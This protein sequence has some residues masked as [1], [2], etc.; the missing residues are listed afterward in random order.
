MTK[1]FKKTAGTD[2]KDLSFFA[3]FSLIFGSMMGS[4]V[5]DIPQNVAHQAGAIAVII[6]WVITAIGMLS[7]GAAFVYITR[8]R[9]DIQSGIY[10][11]AKWFWRL[12]WI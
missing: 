9:S 5:F 1:T 8:K 3:L 12:Y 4:G 2:I 7:L 10:G 11:Y 6:S